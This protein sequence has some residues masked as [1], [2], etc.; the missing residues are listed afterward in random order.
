VDQVHEI[1]L[2][3]DGLGNGG[4]DNTHV[5]FAGHGRTQ[6]EIFEV[7]GGEAGARSGNDAVEEN[8]D[9]AEVS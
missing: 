3:N 4:D 9:G 8:F 2:G 7:E 6:V 1:V 5:F